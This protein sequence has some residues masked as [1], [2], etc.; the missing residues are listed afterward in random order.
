MHTHKGLSPGV[1]P[2]PPGLEGEHSASPILLFGHTERQHFLYMLHS[3]HFFLDAR[4]GALLKK[5]CPG[6][7]WQGLRRG[8]PKRCCGGTNSK[9]LKV[10]GQT[11]FCL[12]PSPWHL[13]RVSHP[14]GHSHGHPAFLKCR[15]LLPGLPWAQTANTRHAPCPFNLEGTCRK[16]VFPAN[17]ILAPGSFPPGSFLSNP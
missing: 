16:P 1:C 3:G 9:T 15:F 6:P 2:G 7:I 5:K 12:S 14:P 11:R 17:V 8:V 10:R 13:P 4:F